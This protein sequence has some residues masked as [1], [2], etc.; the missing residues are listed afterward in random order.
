MIYVLLD[1]ASEVVRGKP[2]LA[3]GALVVLQSRIDGLDPA[4]DPVL[5]GIAAG[6]AKSLGPPRRLSQPTGRRLLD[7]G[8]EIR[9]MDGIADHRALRRVRAAPAAL[10][11]GLAG[12][13]SVPVVSFL[14][15][16]RAAPESPL[17]ARRESCRSSSSAPGAR[18]V[19]RP[20]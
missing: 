8:V 12:G 4:P 10:G 3:V 17:M 7:A 14:R 6:T 18:V 13:A 5:L 16:S 2:A 1:R 19:L 15:N 11:L 9:E 20:K